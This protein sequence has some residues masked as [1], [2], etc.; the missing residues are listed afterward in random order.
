MA[1]LADEGVGYV[2]TSPGVLFRRGAE[3]EIRRNLLLGGWVHAVIGLPGEM[4]PH[5]SIP[6][7][8]WVLGQ[9]R[10]TRTNVLLIDASAEYTPE[11]KVSAW[12][13]EGEALANVFHVWVPI[14]ELTAG[15][16][17]ISPSRW[18]LSD[19]MD[20]AKLEQ[21]FKQTWQDMRRASVALSDISNAVA[22]PAIFGTSPVL[23]VAELV[24][25][26]AIETAAARPV[27]KADAGDL[28]GRH[29][30]AAAI[31]RRELPSIGDLDHVEARELTAPGDV[32]LTAMHDVQAMVDDEGGHVPVGG[33][34]RIRLINHAKLDPHYLAD[35]LAGAWNLRLASGATIPRIPVREIE[36]PVPSLHDQRAIHFA[37]SEARRARDLATEAAKAADSMAGIMLTAVRHGITLPTNPTEGL[38][39]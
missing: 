21:A 12:L 33:V 32:L 26:G 9:A 39:R 6:T 7:A 36:V 11:T 24:E 20:D 37:V 38:P 10:K 4:L 28:Q 25:A 23:T 22:A 27:R 5:T 1:H 18:M 34:Y 15:D 16:A 35:A 14:D 19:S 8:L 30:D 31:R 29:V 3:A 17:D 13:S 2:L